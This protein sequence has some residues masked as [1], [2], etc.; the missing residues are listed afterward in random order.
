MSVCFDRHALAVVES[1]YRIADDVESWL[2]GVLKAAKPL[3][4]RGAGI[5]AYTYEVGR[6][7][8]AIHVRTTSSVVATADTPPGFA[9]T[10]G[11]MVAKI[12]T[13]LLP[14]LYCRAPA[15]AVVSELIASLG[16][17]R[18]PAFQPFEV[19]GDFGVCDM[20]GVPAY[21]PGGHG[22]LICAPTVGRD[23]VGRQRL[24]GWSMLRAHLLAGL[25]LQRAFA[26]QSDAEAVVGPDGRVVHA[27][28]AA[29]SSRAREALRSGARAIDAARGAAGRRDPEG[30]VAAWTALVHGEWSLIDRFE[31]DGRRYFVARRNEPRVPEPRGLSRRERQVLAYAALGHSNK[32]IAYTLGLAPSTV[33]SHL[34]SAMRRLGADTIATLALVSPPLGAAPSPERS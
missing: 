32:Q 18:Y 30:A 29:R 17:H 9:D 3:L 10:A 34:R 20:V 26:P 8:D 33:S 21:D 19:M 25:R 13:P 24:R 6:A 14:G 16:A 5:H 1:A 31:S 2:A 15:I 27:E 28:G 12:P 23:V 11:H 7:N 4:D 22:V